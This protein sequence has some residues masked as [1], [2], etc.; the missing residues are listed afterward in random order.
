MT[1]PAGWYPDAYGVLRWWDGYRWTDAAPQ[2]KVHTG[3][4]RVADGTPTNTVWVWLVVAA[5]AAMILFAIVAL[6]QVQPQVQDMLSVYKTGSADNTAIVFQRQGALF[7]NPWYIANIIFP[8]VACG[9]AIWFAY[10]D[11]KALRQRGY[12]RP[13]HWGWAFLG[14]NMYA[15]SLVYAI[16]RTIVIRRRGG[17]GTAPMV[18]SIIVE[19]ATLIGVGAYM[20]FYMSQVLTAH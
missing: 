16:G 20:V 1:A 5:Q 7:G 14:I 6:S 2:P 15:C 12:D 10:L 9:A 18:A 19:A 8:F 4:A 11:N 3:P 17:R 13:F